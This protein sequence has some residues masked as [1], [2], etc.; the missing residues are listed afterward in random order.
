M[1]KPIVTQTYK[2]P[3]TYPRGISYMDGQYLPMDQAKI[4]VLDWGFLRSDATYDV[5]HVWDGSFFRL[6]HY[7]DRFFNSVDKLHM[8]LPV[9]KAELK[10]ILHN[11][12]RLSGLK[13]AYV[14]MVCT[15]GT[16]PTF[17]R[18]P[19]DA[20]NRFMVFA[21]PL[22]FVANDE[23]L[24]RGLHI[25]ISR[26]V[27]ISPKSVDPTV[28]NY[29]WLDLI[30]GLYEAYDKGA[31]NTLLIDDDG[32]IA[33]GPGFNIFCI[34]NGTLLTPATGV[35][36][37][38]TRQTT[39]DLARELGFDAE[40]RS[41]SQQEIKSADEVFIT[42]TAGGPMYVSRIDDAVIATD[43]AGPIFKQ[44]R[45]L[46]WQKHKDPAWIEVVDYTD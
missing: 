29:H 11:C 4:S 34:K 25:N 1:K 3:H 35:L 41:V 10:D 27:R 12:V 19:R 18:D 40:I 17:S 32:N 46:Y 30:A 31:E 5:A 2:D 7:I 6:D 14:E 33:E 43:G 28:K 23:Q 8:S 45:D 13:N 38:I 22:G 9:D 44:I 21:I 16:S 20:K 26:H 39:L 24:A 15:R 36:L 42:S 37:G